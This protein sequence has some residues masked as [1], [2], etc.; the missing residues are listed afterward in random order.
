MGVQG[1]DK[2]VGATIQGKKRSASSE[3]AGDSVAMST[4]DE[5]Y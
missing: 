4:R 2:K 3:E 1:K 5:W